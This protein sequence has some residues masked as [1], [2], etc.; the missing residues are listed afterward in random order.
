[1][2]GAFE[3]IPEGAFEQAGREKGTGYFSLQDKLALC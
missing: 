3:I 1:V 2:V